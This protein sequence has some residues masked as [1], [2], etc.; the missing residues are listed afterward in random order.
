MVT[1]LHGGCLDQPLLI[2]E[3]EAEA[4]RKGGTHPRSPPVSSGC[5]YLMKV[6]AVLYSEFGTGAC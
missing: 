4:W 3:G 2:K 5:L 6:D 1:G